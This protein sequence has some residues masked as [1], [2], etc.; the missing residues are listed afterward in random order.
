MGPIPLILLP[1][2]LMDGA[3]L[4]TIASGLVQPAQVE[5]LGVED[6]FDRELE[7]LAT[8]APQPT[9]WIGH[10]LGGI[11]ALHLAAQRPSCCAAVVVIASNAR[12][13]GPQG[14]HNR[15][16][17]WEAL[18]RGG[19]AA[20]LHEQLAPVYGI[21]PDD[22]LYDALQGQAEGIGV[23]RFQRQLRYAAERAGLAGA[24]SALPMPV[25][26]LSGSED[27]LC[28]PACGEEIMALSTN[29]LSRH[30]VLPGAGHLLPLQEPDWC[31]RQIRQFLNQLAQG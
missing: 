18:D 17:Q 24:A 7:R 20:L 1:G 19:M 22:P 30:T 25:L 2:T 31:T 3:A 16:L 21:A 10:S 11:A 29:R 28:P 26:A 8:L 6:A 12:A 14:T 9:I 4:R 15:A 27:P 23:Q 5:L 13:D